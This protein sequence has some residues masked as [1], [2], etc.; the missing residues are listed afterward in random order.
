[1]DLSRKK[2]YKF[3]LG[4]CSRSLPSI[5]LH[6]KIS[7]TGVFKERGLYPWAM[8]Q[9]SLLIILTHEVRAIVFKEKKK[10]YL[11]CV[12]NYTALNEFS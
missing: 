7:R 11:W 10:K 8:V 3:D 5:P 6:L 1:M 4:H 12:L 9:S 2:R